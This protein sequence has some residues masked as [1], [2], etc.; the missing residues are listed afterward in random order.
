MD[1]QEHDQVPDPPDTEHNLHPKLRM[2]NLN[3]DIDNQLVKAETDT[4]E[5]KIAGVLLDC[6]QVPSPPRHTIPDTLPLFRG[7]EKDAG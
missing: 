7:L 4:S 2:K 5:I 3:D 6:D 1:D